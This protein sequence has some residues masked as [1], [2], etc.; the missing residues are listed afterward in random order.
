MRHT[1]LAQRLTL[2]LR[3]KHAQV[4]T[5]GLPNRLLQAW[6]RST[7]DWHPGTPAREKQKHD[8]PHITKAKQHKGIMGVRTIIR[9]Q[10]HHGTKAS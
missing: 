5:P 1:G 6:H 3:E 9:A 4:H 8:S 10:R 2:G 7:L